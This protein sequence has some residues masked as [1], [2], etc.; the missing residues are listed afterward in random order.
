MNHAP[1]LGRAILLKG[2]AVLSSLALFWLLAEFML[3]GRKFAPEYKMPDRSIL[4]LDE[5]VLFRFKPR[6]R[7][8]YNDMGYRDG[9]FYADKGRAKRIL[10]MGDSFVTGLLMRSDQTM[11]ETLERQ[12]GPPWQVY[13]MGIVG[14]GPDQTWRRLLGDG[15]QFDPDMV[16]LGLFPANDFGDL[17]KNRLVGLDEAGELFLRRDNIVRISLARSRLWMLLRKTFSGSYTSK[18]TETYLF[19]ALMHDAFLILDNMADAE[20]EYLVALMRAVLGEIKGTLEARSVDFKV[21]IIPPM[22]FY[23]EDRRSVPEKHEPRVAVSNDAKVIEI[24]RELGIDW[25]YLRD[26]FPEEGAEAFYD[27]W[28]THF[29]AEGARVAAEHIREHLLGM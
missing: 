9:K 2:L 3:I 8:D 13:N 29:T 4:Q 16:I 26:T 14:D 11:P 25:L 7:F 1:A 21:V 5:D 20:R 6:S 28:D 23:A 27:P 15:L 24:C 12:L 10:F 19:R 17:Q 18:Q 22:Q